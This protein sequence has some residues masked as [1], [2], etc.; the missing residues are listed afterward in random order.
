MSQPI[1][2]SDFRPTFKEEADK[3]AL[4]YAEL[5]VTTNFSFLRGASP[6]KA[7][8]KQAASLGYAAIGIADRNSLAG[9]VRAYA[10]W[11]KLTP[12][13]LAKLNAAT[14]RP[15]FWPTPEIARV[16]AGCA[17][18]FRSASFVRTRAGVCWISRTC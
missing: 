17:G 14:A 18:C 10:A 4:R 6:P 7:F 15:T 5:A 16:M 13:K 3:P 12:E 9:V 2:L 8:V 11:K 1:V